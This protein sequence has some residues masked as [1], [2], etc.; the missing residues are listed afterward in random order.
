MSEIPGGGQLVPHHGHKG[1]AAAS[2]GG[3]PGG[4]LTRATE[5]QKMM[6]LSSSSS[7][8]RVARDNNNNKDWALPGGTVARYV[9]PGRTTRP[10]MHNEAQLRASRVV[11]PPPSE[12]AAALAR[13]QTTVRPGTLTA[14][15]GDD[16]GHGWLCGCRPAGAGAGRDAQDSPWPGDASKSQEDSKPPVA[17]INVKA[18]DHG[19]GT[20]GTGHG[21][22]NT[23]RSVL[24]SLM[25][26]IKGDPPS[27]RS[28]RPAKAAAAGAAG[29]PL[30]EAAHAAPVMVR[31][32][33]NCSA[34]S[35]R[36]ADAALALEA[37]FRKM[38]RDYEERMRS[39]QASVEEMMRTIAAQLQQLQLATT[40]TVPTAGPAATDIVTTTTGTAA[41]ADREQQQLVLVKKPLQPH[42]DSDAAAAAHVVD[43]VVVDSKPPP[44]SCPPATATAAPVKA[45][46]PPPAHLLP[47]QQA[48]VLKFRSDTF[49]VHPP[50][51]LPAA[52]AS[53]SSSATS[54]ASNSDDDDGSARGDD[55]PHPRSPSPPRLSL[56][57]LD[58]AT[59]AARRA[60]HLF[61]D[62]LVSG[63]DPAAV[64]AI[65]GGLLPR[66]RF[67][68]PRDA[69]F[70]L[71]SCVAGA[72]F[73][74]FHLPFYG[75]LPSA[76]AAPPPSSPSSP[77]SSD[78]CA[79]RTSSSG[80]SATGSTRRSAQACWAAYRRLANARPRDVIADRGPGS[81]ASFH[82]FCQTKLALFQ[83]E[84]KWVDAWSVPMLDAFLDAA[85]AVWRLHLLALAVR[86]A[87]A[88]IHASQFDRFRPDYMEMVHAC[89]GGGQG[90]DAAGGVGVRVDDSVFAPSVEFTVMPGFKTQLGFVRCQ[91]Y[92]KVRA[93]SRTDTHGR[94][95]TL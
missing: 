53:S 48:V 83:D 56:A 44:P 57:A 61:A 43:L 17:S 8:S 26:L 75:L 31:S 12:S 34:L 62:R 51:S 63:H 23:P 60:L 92:L 41:A 59:R 89:D 82:R 90:E 77:S 6:M 46:A 35:Q 38:A 58:Q 7:S 13:P 93:R 70:G 15:A 28:S 94:H 47:Q 87:P 68:R 19:T 88:L 22:S 80:N 40:G 24:R 2:P 73:A 39:M 67:L 33:S 49:R 42:S 14:A 11:M 79:S 65:V 54:S 18:R 64:C 32:C 81:H 16:R 45:E 86:P 25:R 1:S 69:R 3:A 76:A 36:N 10:A 29:A 27:P 50:E 91:V 37:E 55:R 74:D 30:K 9:S 20:S 21:G 78:G 66:V 5:Y 52:P 85:M 71:E 72:F 4:G 84:V 95:M